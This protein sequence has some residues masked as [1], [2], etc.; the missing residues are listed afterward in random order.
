MSDMIAIAEGIGAA[1]TVS[2]D[3]QLTAGLTA[4]TLVMTFL[5]LQQAWAKKLSED[6]EA[7]YV[8]NM[9]VP[10]NPE[11]T[12][13]VAAKQ[14][15]RTV[16]STCSDKETGNLDTLIQGQKAQAQ[17]LANAMTEAYSIGEPVFQL[18]SAITDTVQVLG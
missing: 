15:Q 5:P 2:T 9:N 1:A 14:Q 8:A 10:G 3:S 13:E 4:I 11:G 17:I 7:I 16:D 6:A 18:M 12:V